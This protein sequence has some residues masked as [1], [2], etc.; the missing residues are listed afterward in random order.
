MY[1]TILQNVQNI[2]VMRRLS[3]AYLMKS[4]YIYLYCN[5]CP[6]ILGHSDTCNHLY[7]QYKLL[8]YYTDSSYIPIFLQSLI[9]ILEKINKSKFILLAI[10]NNALHKV[11]LKKFCLVNNQFNNFKTFFSGPTTQKMKRI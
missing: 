9:S 11:P 4:N 2:S 10:Q 8:R 3:L 5:F 1:R 6:S 7:P